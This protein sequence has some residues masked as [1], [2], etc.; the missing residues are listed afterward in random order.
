MPIYI[1]FPVNNAEAIPYFSIEWQTML[2]YFCRQRQL[3]PKQ[4]CKG[5]VQLF[6]HQLGIEPTEIAIQAVENYSMIFEKVQS[7]KDYLADVY[8][9][10]FAIETS[11]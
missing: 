1:G 10:I 9:H 3:Q 5:D 2:H 7:S 6:L 11:Y 4:L 8:G